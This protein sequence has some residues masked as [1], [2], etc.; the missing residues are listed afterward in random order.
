[1]YKDGVL[2]SETTVQSAMNASTSRTLIGAVNNN[3]SLDTTNYAQMFNGYIQDVRISK[4][5]VYTSCFDAPKTFQADVE[6]I[7]ANEPSCEEVALNIQSDTTTE[8]DAITDISVNAH[9]ITKNGNVTHSAEQTI[10]GESS[11][12]FDGNGDYLSINQS[13]TLNLQGDFT[14]NVWFNMMSITEPIQTLTLS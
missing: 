9:S 2:E 3:G 6:P 11:L 13:E 12:Y 14:L 5:A 8:T 1:M 10:S 4:K 7:P